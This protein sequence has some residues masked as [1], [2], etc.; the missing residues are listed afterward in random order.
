MS[1]TDDA[2]AAVSSSSPAP[3]QPNPPK[4]EPKGAPEPEKAP[5][6][7]PVDD[8]RLDADGFCKRCGFQWE[9]ETNETEEGR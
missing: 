9:P 8:K 5:E 1:P 4:A 6:R 7:C 2:P 3:T